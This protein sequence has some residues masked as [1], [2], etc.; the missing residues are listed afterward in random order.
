MRWGDSSSVRSSHS[1]EN[2][3]R[4]PPARSEALYELMRLLDLIAQ[5]RAESI[6]TSDGCSL[7]GA[8]RFKRAIHACPVRFVFTDDLTCCATQLAYADGDR[9]ASCLDLIR[10]PAQSLWVEWADGP[11]QEVLRT[12]ELL[13]PQPEARAQRAGALFTSNLGGRSGEFRTFWSTPEQRAYVSP[14]IIRFDFDRSPQGGESADDVFGLC[15]ARVAEH[16]LGLD[17]VLEHVRF[18][19]DTEWSRYYQE[20]CTTSQMRQEVWD[21]NLAAC[22]FDPPM[23]FA[24]FLMLCARDALPQREIPVDRLNRSRRRTGKPPLL[25]HVE[26]AAPLFAPRPAHASPDSGGVEIARRS[27]RLHHVC[28]HIV[29]RGTMVFWRCPHIRGS[30]RLGQ[31]RSRTV[32]LSY[33]DGRSSIPRVGL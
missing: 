32:R 27:P 4:T 2:C 9:L 29:R 23:L 18:R 3:Y 16:P 24:F 30:A 8:E 26:V 10:V 14:V 12:I 15:R 17:Q 13:S 20:R 22:A 6:R 21:A 28:G 5:G 7:P 31:I 33:G 19:F 11:R 1:S 25:E